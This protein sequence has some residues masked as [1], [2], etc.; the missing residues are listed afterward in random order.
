MRFFEQHKVCLPSGAKVDGKPTYPETEEELEDAWNEICQQYIFL[1]PGGSG[2]RVEQFLKIP[3]F[4]KVNRR[5]E[6]PFLPYWFKDKTQ[7]YIPD[8]QGGWSGPI[9]S[10]YRRLDSIMRSYW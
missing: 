4:M 3:D 8:F 9:V 2:L 1:Y 5:K 7:G 6:S 10:Y